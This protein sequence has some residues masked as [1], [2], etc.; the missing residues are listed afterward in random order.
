MPPCPGI[1]QSSLSWRPP[2]S[3]KPLRRRR[4]AA[5]GFST[6]VHMTSTCQ[7]ATA[8]PPLAAA[9]YRPLTTA[10]AGAAAAAAAG[11]QPELRCTTLWSPWL[12]SCCGNDQCCCTSMGH[13][14]LCAVDLANQPCRSLAGAASRRLTAR[15]PNSR[16]RECCRSG[17]GGSVRCSGCCHSCAECRQGGW[18]DRGWCSCASAHPA[19]HRAA[20]WRGVCRP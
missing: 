9:A 17:S 1:A 20:Q 18:G 4:R 7:A 11:S 10:A 6:P 15:L 14:R 19:R 2:S 5:A 13:R 12:G 3:A 16:V 8:I